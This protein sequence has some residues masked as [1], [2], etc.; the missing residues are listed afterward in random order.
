MNY[1]EMVLIL[2]K[3]GI[4]FKRRNWNSKYIKYFY[5]A[6]KYIFDTNNRLDGWYIYYPTHEDYHA[7]N[8]EIV[9]KI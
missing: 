2:E 3:E 1:L 9:N 7:D 5:G 8:W 4:K 6:G